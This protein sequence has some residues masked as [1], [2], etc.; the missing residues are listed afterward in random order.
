MK[1]NELRLK[2]NFMLKAKMIEL[3]EHGCTQSDLSSLTGATRITINGVMNDRVQL[4]IESVCRHLDTLA[5]D[6]ALKVGV[7]HDNQ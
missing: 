4:S 3:Q 5:V 6:Y 7:S 2:L 1:V